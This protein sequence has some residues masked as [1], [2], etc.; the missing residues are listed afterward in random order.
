MFDSMRACAATFDMQCHG[1]YNCTENWPLF[2]VYPQA[3]YP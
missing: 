2:A 3:A 1:L